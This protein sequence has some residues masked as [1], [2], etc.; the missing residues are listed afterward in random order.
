VL[1]LHAQVDGLAARLP[2]AEPGGPAR[3]LALIDLPLLRGHVLGRIADYERAAELAGQLV[4]GTT[5][6]GRAGDGTA[7]LARARTRA[8]LHRF[9]AALADLQAAEERGLDRTTVAAERAEILQA[10]G[11]EAEAGE[12][13]HGAARRRPGFATLGALAV[14]QA[15][16][17][18]LADA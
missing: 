8:V 1:N 3:S 11:A 6:D 2:R 12:L 9:T 14:F 13:H 5:G 4:R 10:T 16:R 7:L 18:E 15:E 17:G